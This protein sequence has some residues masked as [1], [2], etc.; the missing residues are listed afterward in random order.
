[1]A[2]LTGSQE[3]AALSGAT[4]LGERAALNDFVVPGR[5]SAGGGCR[6]LDTRDGHVA[7]SLARPEDRALLPALFGDATTSPNDDEELALRLSREY[8]AEIVKRGRELGL[9]IANLDEQPVGPACRMS[10]DGPAATPSPRQPLV[11]DL[12]ALWAGPLAAHLL[13]LA[14]AEVVKIESSNRQD[15]MRQGDP[16]LFARLNQHKANVAID[17][18]EQDQRDALI[19]LIRRADIV[20]EAARPRALLQ[21]GIDANQLVREVPGL[22]WV[23]ITGHGIAGDAVNWTGFGDDCSVAG[24]LSAALLAASGTVGFAGDA[25]AD[26]LTG[27][28][29]ARRA[30]EQRKRGTGAR[31]VVSMSGVVA[32]ALA[33]ERER[34]EVALAKSL[35]NWADARGRPF[36]E[37]ELRPAGRVAELGQ[38]NA[39]WLEACWSC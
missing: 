16:A 24:G 33:A 19:A 3:I 14:G 21:L 6:L 20:I 7:L 25:C 11:I 27:I 35:Q 30:L 8:A 2:T 17:L 5:V 10:D 15:T 23:T 28:Y 9:A 4:L 12:S 31:L 18:R 38:D 36:P 34:D 29:A 13:G 26:P 39:T 32:Q 1:M 37:V 22:V